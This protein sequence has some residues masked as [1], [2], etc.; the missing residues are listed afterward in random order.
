LNNKKIRQINLDPYSADIRKITGIMDKNLSEIE[1][2]FNVDIIFRDNSLKIMGQ[3]DDVVKAEEAILNLFKAGKNRENIDN[4]TLNY[5]LSMTGK[6]LDKD[7]L[8]NS[9]IICYTARGKAIKYK[10]AGQKKYINAIKRNDITFAIGPAGTGKTYLAMAMAVEAFK[11][12]DV[13]RIVLTRPAVEAGESLGFLPGDLREKVDPY[14]RPLYDALYD[15]MG[16]E[17]YQKYMERGMIEVAPLAYMRGRTLDDSFIVL[18]EAQNTTPEQ[19]KM[20]LTRLGFGSKAIVTGDITQVD[21]PNDKTSGLVKVQHILGNIKGLE[22]IY[23]TQQ[24][25]VRHSLVQ[26]IID[27]YDNYENNK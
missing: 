11:K 6:T 10:T 8:E 9:N 4:Q 14:L 20:F 2:Y 22:F 5:I 1:K 13:A 15:I 26:R 16:V 27:A 3:E 17:V 19:M 7:Y 24:D 25:V 23:L 18:D 12:G 21:L